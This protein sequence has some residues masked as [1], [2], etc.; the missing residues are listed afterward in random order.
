MSST[1]DPLV[2]RI[3]RLQVA[4][5][6][7]R[8][9]LRERTDS[10]ALHDLRTSVRR[11]R[12][13]LRPLRDVPG[14]GRLEQAAKAVGELTTPLRDREVLAAQLLARDYPTA[15][16]KRLRQ[17][18]R[19]YPLVADS[20]QL[21]LLMAV[22]DAFPQF[23][24]AA[25]RQHVLSGLNKKLE[26]HLDKQ[27]KK[28]RRALAD[29]AHD[30]HRLR[31]LIKRLRYCTEAYPEQ[32]R[33][34]ASIVWQLKKAQGALGDWHDHWQWLSQAE[35]QADLADCVPSWQMSLHR[36]EQKADR[37]LDSLARSMR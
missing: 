16:H 35:Q 27:A 4:L 29:P 9:R 18:A 24:R 22:L 19:A 17:M 34:R 1:V 15:A 13:L 14:V 21:L 6:A 12:S 32:S 28:L 33:L 20:P 8:E 10:E 5:M 37:V 30:R 7:C 23:I 3:L 26:R 31:L 2:S 11:L 36:T 25:Q